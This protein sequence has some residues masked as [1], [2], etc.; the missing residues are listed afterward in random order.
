MPR[1]RANPDTAHGEVS[2]KKRKEDEVIGIPTILPWSGN[3]NAKIW[4]L[5]SGLSRPENFKV[6]FGK[7][8]QKEVE[9]YLFCLFAARAEDGAD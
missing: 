5:I 8:E 4:E 3:K 2:V 7:K 6:L 9:Y 1:K